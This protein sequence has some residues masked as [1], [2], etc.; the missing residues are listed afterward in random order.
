MK[1]TLL[2]TQFFPP[3]PGGAQNYFYQLCKHLPEESVVVLTDDTYKEDFKHL[4]P[5]FNFEV[6]YK[7]FFAERMWPK[8]L[9]IIGHLIRTVHKYKIEMIWAGE[10]LPAGIAVLLFSKIFHI[11]YFTTTHG[12]DVLNPMKAP[13]LKGKWKRFLLRPVLNNAKF[14]TANSEY[15]RLLLSKEGVQHEKTIVV[16]PSANHTPPASELAFSAIIDETQKLKKEGYKIILGVSRLDRRKG[17][18]QVIKAMPLVY[19]KYDK[20]AYVIVGSGEY[21]N[22]L[23]RMAD[24]VGGMIFFTGPA[25]DEDTKALYTMCDIFILMPR[26]IHGLIEGFGIVY[27]EAG[28]FGKPV[29]GSKVGG[30]PEAVVDLYD[31]NIDTATGLLVDNPMDTKQIA[32]KIVM[33]LKDEGLAKKLGENGAK[34]A[35]QFTWQSGADVI[36]SK[37]I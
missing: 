29:I 23:E 21:R 5:E 22:D 11:P 28:L 6:I 19:K 37:L 32:K 18:D 26:E 10:V 30:V 3:F 34:H 24:T 9:K 2:V 1:K 35:K 17:I 13:G 15:T 20:V 4:Q 14:I 33:L 12:A 16:Y 27:I 25:T 7:P 36:K 31:G 8:W